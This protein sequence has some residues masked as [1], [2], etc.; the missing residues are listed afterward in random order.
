[1]IFYSEKYNIR[2]H[3]IESLHAF[4]A[5]KYEKIIKYLMSNKFNPAY[6]CLVQN[7][8][9]ENDLLTVHSKEYIDSTK[10]LEKLSDIL[11]LP[12]LES[13]IKFA[14]KLPIIPTYILK[15]KDISDIILS[16]VKY[17]VQGTI[18]AS[19]F[20]I[21]E[22][23]RRKFSINISG[24]Y[25]HAKKN[26]GGG[27]CIYSDIAIAINILKNQGYIKTSE[28]IAIIDLDAHQ[29]NGLESIFLG[30]NTVKIFD[31][32][33][34]EIYPNDLYARNKLT[35]EDGNLNIPLNHG[36]KGSDYLAKLRSF[37]PLFI[38]KI[39]NLKMVFFNAGTDV[40]INDPLGGLSL[41]ESDI[42]ERDKFVINYL[43]NNKISWVMLSSGG[44]TKNSYK[45]TAKSIEYAFNRTN[46]N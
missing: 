26:S 30:D 4:D 1:M 25:H 15:K 23:N 35:N 36:E 33:N 45:L 19:K 21:N 42:Y 40:Y 32:Y 16:P 12:I 28:N 46:S 13:L 5:N 10:S 22:D 6:I 18:N 38:S 31:M 20:A 44:Y 37:L 39:E 34:R 27:F 2:L 3:G 41:T 14:K 7:P 17:A 8:C 43:V 29:G 11:E 24:G 9:T